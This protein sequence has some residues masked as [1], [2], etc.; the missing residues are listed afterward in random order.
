MRKNAAAREG[1]G[2][3]LKSARARGRTGGRPR[4]DSEQVKKAI[5]PCCF[6]GEMRQ[7][8]RGKIAENPKIFSFL[9]IDRLR[10][11]LYDNLGMVLLKS[12]LGIQ[13]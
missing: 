10:F 3:G 6:R 9:R 1:P 12:A 13:G 7:K 11:W 4:V 8:N 5:K 2:K